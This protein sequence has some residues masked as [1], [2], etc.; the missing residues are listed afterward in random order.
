[1]TEMATNGEPARSAR[2]TTQRTRGAPLR[3]ALVGI[4]KIARDQHIPALEKD[5]AFELAATVSRNHQ[6]DG[7][8]AFRDIPSLLE[9]G[10]PIDAVSL[11]TPPVGRHA[12][13]RAALDAGLH[14]MLEKPPGAT[15]SEVEDL[16]ARAR[17]RN[18]TLFTTWHSRESA[19]VDP[20]R[21]WLARRTIKSVRTT[22]KEDIR[23]WHPGQD[24]I[25]EPGG[26]GVFDPGINALSIL[27][28]I[29]PER[30]MLRRATL[31]FPANRQAPIAAELEL[32]HGA[33][34]PVVVELDF[35]QVGPQSW[36]IEVETNEGT[37]LLR[38]GGRR[39]FIDGVEQLAAEDCEYPR[40]YRRFDELIAAGTSDVDVSPQQLVADA[41][42]IGR[43]IEAA[44]FEF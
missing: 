33:N 37:L 27:T 28:S 19:A 16:A 5:A 13:A 38:E 40:L 42:M 6:V 31:H 3:I 43:R 26:L 39:L 23:H 15:V 36:D 25:L 21:D 14:V 2:E 7:V 12:L 24:W 17:A 35:L 44:P 10:L 29:L 41:F 20:A 8:R 4:G 11:C 1:M 22:W 34:D 9:A 30:L 18:L 32:Q